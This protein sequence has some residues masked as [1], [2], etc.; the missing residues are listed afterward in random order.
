MAKNPSV[1]N[2]AENDANNA[3]T[4]MM[5]IWK[6]SLLRSQKE[7]QTAVKTANSEKEARADLEQKIRN[8]QTECPTCASR[9]YK[10]QSSDG[11]VSFQ[12]AKSIPMS[13]AG[14]AVSAHEHEHVSAGASEETDEVVKNS[15][16]SLN[17]GRCP[18]CGRTYVSGG[19]TKTTSRPASY[20]GNFRPGGMDIKV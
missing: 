1:I 12:A 18:D 17:Y 16:V 15:T 3:R 20:K 13:T 7:R 4:N 6:E 8:G 14:V 5:D 19:V 2:A 10:D 11:G 9:T